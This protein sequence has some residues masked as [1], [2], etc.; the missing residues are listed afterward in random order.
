MN[1]LDQLEA[2]AIHIFREAAATLKNPVL[3]YSIGKDSSVL[4][5][6]A[7]KAFHPAPIP[8]PLLHVDTGFEFPEMAEF[9]DYFVAKIGAEVI[10]VQN[11]E[12][13][14]EKFT[15]DDTHTEQYVYYKKSKPLVE[16]IREYG[17]DG[18]FGG[19]RR[20]EEKSRAKERV[21]S[22]RTESQAWDPKNQ[23]PELWHLYNGHAKKGESFRI[24]PI[25]NWTEMDVWEYIVREQIEIVSLYYAKEMDVVV[26]DGVTLRI[27]NFVQ[28]REREDVLRGIYR[29]RTLGC[30]PST[31]AVA[32][33]AQTAEL[34]LEEIITSKASERQNRA[35]DQTSDSSMEKKKKEG[36]F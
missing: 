27:D 2:E 17:F 30:A 31:G 14:A 9:R 29:Y 12:P 21:F 33:S 11:R 35:I 8:F 18:G 25:S 1:T 16:T 10:V 19:A 6:L 22:H 36:H 34:I 20:D 15:K 26:R 4:L 3:F 7:R 32:S 5:H 28:P 24:F 23:R 13:E